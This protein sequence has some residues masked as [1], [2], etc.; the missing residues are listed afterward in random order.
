[1][2]VFY[3]NHT[4]NPSETQKTYYA[5]EAKCIL[6]PI[7]DTVAI[8]ATISITD[9]VAHI[10][11]TKSIGLLL[12]HS[13]IYQ[14]SMG[15]QIDLPRYTRYTCTHFNNAHTCFLKQEEYW[16]QNETTYFGCFRNMHILTPIHSYVNQI[17]ILPF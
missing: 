12:A 7:T 17:I 8:T 16:K 2:S 4:K 10:Y 15:I 6:L 14:V 3:P 1:M 13:D 5:N 9:T 11:N